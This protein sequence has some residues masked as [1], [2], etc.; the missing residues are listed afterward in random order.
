M[1]VPENLVYFLGVSVVLTLAPGPDVIFLASQGLAGGPRAGLA[2]A[3]GLSSGLLVHTTL[4]ALGVSA[5]F[6][7]SPAAFGLVKWAGAVYMAWL[8]WCAFRERPPAAG[9]QAP[10]GSA[11]ALYRRGIIMNLLNPKVALFFLALLPQFVNPAR[12]GVR[13]QM[14]VLGLVFMAQVVVVFGAIGYL[15]GRLGARLLPGPRHARAI[16]AAKGLVFLSVAVLLSL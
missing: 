12:G 6:A 9:A 5:V 8:A 7:A 10:A 1:L 2:V 14:L 16:A 15:S 13:G 3:L 11:A 4:A